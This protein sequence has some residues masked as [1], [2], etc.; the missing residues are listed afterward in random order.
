MQ[1]TAFLRVGLAWK[2]AGANLLIA[3]AAIAAIASGHRFGKHGM[4]TLLVV[5]AT[6]IAALAV[7]LILVRIALRP[8]H[9]LETTVQRVVEGDFAARVPRSAIADV[10]M[11]RVASVVNALLDTV[12][13]DRV[14]MRQLAS[15]IIDMSERQRAAV[16][17]ELHD[18]TAQTLAAVMM[19]VGMAARE[20]SN[21]LLAARL[22]VLHDSLGDITEEVRLLAH[23][24]HPR[25]LEDLGLAAALRELVR[26]AGRSS[27]ASITVEESGDVSHIPLPAASALFRLAEE[28][29][30]NAV[31]HA[32]ASHIRV[33]LTTEVVDGGHAML[34]IS[35]DGEGF[36]VER[37]DRS[38]DGTG[39]FAMRQRLALVNGTCEIRSVRGRGTQVLA[40]VPLVPE[41][42][43]A[44]AT[45]ER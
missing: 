5:T 21:P 3:M 24:I 13:T 2:L 30:G 18:S 14:R 40:R 9:E 22:S 45:Y 32:N 19:Q 25:V 28:A 41:R 6:I 16:A 44:G 20:E 31:R 23:D 15:H 27:N 10:E 34:E 29:L 37:I 1:R 11:T 17:H 8:L 43:L 35:D 26:E 42:F 39:L 33:V 36:D 7:N 4:P 38:G 12:S